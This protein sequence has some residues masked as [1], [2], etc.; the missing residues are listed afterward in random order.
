MISFTKGETMNQKRDEELEELL[1]KVLNA[2]LREELRTALLYFSQTLGD[3]GKA[4]KE[5]LKENIGRK[6]L[7]KV[8]RILQEIEENK[9]TLEELAKKITNY[10][11]QMTYAQ[12]SIFFSCYNTINEVSDKEESQKAM[13]YIEKL[14]EQLEQENQKDSK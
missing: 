8:I 5:I 1:S 9:K 4:T 6:E 11:K 14:V 2:A 7:K 13:R 3:S 10:K 12:F